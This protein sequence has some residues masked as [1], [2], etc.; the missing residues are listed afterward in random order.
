MANLSMKCQFCQRKGFKVISTHHAHCE[1]KRNADDRIISKRCK[2]KYSFKVEKIERTHEIKFLEQRNVY[3]KEELEK[4]DQIIEEMR[5][6]LE[7]RDQIIDEIRKE[8][9]EIRKESKTVYNNCRIQTM[10]ISP[11]AF[12][13]ECKRF[14]STYVR[15]VKSEY[16]ENFAKNAV[17]H[18]K[19]EIGKSDESEETKKKFI[20][21]LDNDEELQVDILNL[22]GYN[23]KKT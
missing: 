3:L 5:K 14:I 17:S 2:R 4:R 10:L 1:M 16:S 9:E 6:E 8:S 11:A 7:K 18:L 21:M 19:A 15:S 13:D 12:G 23:N 22:L 20:H